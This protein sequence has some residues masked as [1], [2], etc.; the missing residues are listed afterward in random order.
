[1]R[2]V[3]QRSTFSVMTAGITT[4]FTSYIYAFSTS[5]I[6]TMYLPSSVL[7]V[8]ANRMRTHLQQ[9]IKRSL[10][11]TQLNTNSNVISKNDASLQAEQKKQTRNNF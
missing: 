7:N 8:F 6:H 1:M 10:V 2:T 11:T 4:T 3:I 9:W 5:T